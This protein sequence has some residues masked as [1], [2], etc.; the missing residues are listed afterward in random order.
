M[1]LRV[2]FSDL[3]NQVGSGSKVQTLANNSVSSGIDINSCEAVAGSED[4]ILA[5]LIWNDPRDHNS[6]KTQYASRYENIQRIVR[7]HA[8]KAGLSDCR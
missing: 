2:L 3:K 6:G 8:A 5:S 1:I 4:Q 7:G